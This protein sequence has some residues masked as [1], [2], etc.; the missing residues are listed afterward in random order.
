MGFSKKYGTE[1]EFQKKL[2]AYAY[3]NGAPQGIK[4]VKELIKQGL[5]NIVLK[6]RVTEG[7]NW[8]RFVSILA[9]NGFECVEQ[10]EQFLVYVRNE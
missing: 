2:R 7:K 9:R 3:I 10:N 1:K 5:V 6:T 8:T 4:E